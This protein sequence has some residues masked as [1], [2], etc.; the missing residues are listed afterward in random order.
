MR[1]DLTEAK[2]RGPKDDLGTTQ[3]EHLILVITVA[4]SFAAAAV[5]LGALLL[6]YHEGIEFV[7]ALPLP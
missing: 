1:P 3:V 6:R 2:T 4:L 7:L 5:P